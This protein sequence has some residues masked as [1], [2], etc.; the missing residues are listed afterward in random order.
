[1]NSSLVVKSMR[2]N[3]DAN[4]VD[5]IMDAIEEERDL[6]DQIAEAITRPGQDMFDDVR[7]AC[8]SLALAMLMLFAG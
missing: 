5:K 8:H 3:L 6:A 2:G 4:R 1:M 7:H